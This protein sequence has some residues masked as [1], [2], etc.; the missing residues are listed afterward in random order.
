MGSELQRYES[1]QKLAEWSEKVSSCRSSGKTVR[2]WCEENGI[3]PGSYYRWQRILFNMA[4]AERSLPEARP[5]FAEIPISKKAAPTAVIRLGN[6]EIE[7]F[8][9]IDE[10]TLQTVCQ[11]VRY[12][13]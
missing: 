6:A 11:V 8:P 4:A 10:A 5:Q 7:I 3:S 1:R 2:D 12:A 13:E 9:G